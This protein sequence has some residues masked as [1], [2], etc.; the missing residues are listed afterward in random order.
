VTLWLERSPAKV[1][2]WIWFSVGSYRKDFKN[3]ICCFSCFNAQH[4][5]IAQ[6]IKSSQWIIRQWK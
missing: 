5:R 2:N 6:R 4:L 1:V 3:G